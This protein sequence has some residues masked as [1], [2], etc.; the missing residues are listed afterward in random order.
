MWELIAIPALTGAVALWFG[1]NISSE[2]HQVV[3]QIFEQ[4][5]ISIK[6]GKDHQYPQ[7]VRE[8]KSTKQ[9]KLIYRTPL[10][11]EEKT[12][13][14]LQQILSVTLNFTSTRLYRIG[15]L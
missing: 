8:C 5:H 6:N 9:I 14:T 7:L 4:Y 3:Q 2:E 15:V 1:K 10:A 12:L 13:R 11:L